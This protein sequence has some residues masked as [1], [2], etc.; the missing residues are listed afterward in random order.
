MAASVRGLTGHVGSFGRVTD[1]R[2][3]WDVINDSVD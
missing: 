2:C 3:R 1:I